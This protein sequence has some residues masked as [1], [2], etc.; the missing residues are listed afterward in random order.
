[1]VAVRT[2]RND[3]KLAALLLLAE[4]DRLTPPQVVEEARPEGSPLHSEFEWDDSIAAEQHRLTQARALIGSYKVR[5]YDPDV[6]M[7]RFTFVRR[8]DGPRYMKTEDMFDND[9]LR[10]QVLDRMK[11]EADSF[12]RRYERYS[13]AAELVG[14]IRAWLESQEA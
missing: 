9:F 6:K 2:S 12:M 13:E 14:P 4:E 3:P 10:R 8:D 1:M 5:M 11:R 7:R